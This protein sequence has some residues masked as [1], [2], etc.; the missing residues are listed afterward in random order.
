M[1][2]FDIAL[3]LHV[4]AAVIWIGGMFFA[5]FFLRPAMS[6][7]EPPVRLTLW[8]GV[9]SRFFPVVWLCIVVIF[10]SGFYLVYRLGGFVGLGGYVNTMMLLGF[11]MLFVFK[12]VY[13]KPYKDLRHHV[14]AEQWQPAAKAL[15]TIRLCVAINLFLG[16]LTLVVALAFKVW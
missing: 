6:E 16:L 13:I 1:S 11:I 9:L 3:M 10:A 15:A 2:D 8:S 4:V 12:F 14:R 7:L 5:Y